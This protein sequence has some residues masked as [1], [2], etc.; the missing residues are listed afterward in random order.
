MKVFIRRISAIM[1]VFC[2]MGAM[3]PVLGNGTADAA[4]I[5]LNKK[6][7]YIAKGSK[8]KLKVKG[9][10]AKVKW[11][12]S[13]KSIATV[14][15]KGVV[16]G[17]KIG[18]CTVTAKVKGKKYKC[19]VIVEKKS[20]NQARKLR[21]YILKKGKYDRDKKAYFISRSYYTDE[22]KVIARIS[23]KKNSKKLTFDWMYNVGTPEERHEVAV[24]IDL[25]SKTS[26]PGTVYWKFTDLYSEQPDYIEYNGQITKAF[27]GKGLGLS[28]SSIKET[29]LIRDEESNEQIIEND[30]TDPAEFE[31]GV[32]GAS[33]WTK[34]AFTDMKPLFKKAGVT[35]KSIGFSKL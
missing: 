11:K 6:T 1:L 25:I 10:S 5:K 20:C 29:Y 14:T 24:A 4:T 8:V 16:K 17:K 3:I 2:V 31:K 30:V 15:S 32:T 27:N 9:T 34:K 23:A 18:T 22:G 7:V 12:S 35:V 33:N 21:T 19:K 28:I 13:K 26:K